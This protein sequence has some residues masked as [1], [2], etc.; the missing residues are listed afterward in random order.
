MA[1]IFMWLAT[2]TGRLQWYIPH[3]DGSLGSVIDGVFHTGLGSVAERNFR[4][5]V[6]CVRPTPDDKYLCAVE[7]MG[8]TR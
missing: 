8:L 4:P 2:M 7:I 5:H 3:Q 1:D 6:N